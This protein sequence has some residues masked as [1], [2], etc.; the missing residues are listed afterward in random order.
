MTE[1][2]RRPVVLVVGARPGSLGHHIAEHVWLADVQ[3]HRAGIV[4]EP[5]HL[6]VLDDT[7]VFEA[8]MNVKPTH[9][10]C[11]IG[12]NHPEPFY[13]DEWQD[14]AEDHMRVNYLMPMHLL[15]L[16]EDY[17]SG[18]PG[19]FIAISSNSAHIPRSSSAAY[20]A[21]KAALSMGLRCAARDLT[22]AGKPLRVWGYEPGALL[23]TPMTREV[24]RGLGKDVPMSR[25]LTNP[26]GLPVA[27]VARIVARDLLDSPEV[28][29]GCMVRLDN[30]E[31]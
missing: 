14:A 30:G 2:K 20:C 22:R 6:N 16:Y 13:T 19:T 28:L 26:A 23:G 25:M 3:V 9:V 18:L 15:N 5:I 24:T 31:I 4:T 10:V 12:T 11:T 21:S 7:G 17:L 29:H 1:E 27:A 8:F